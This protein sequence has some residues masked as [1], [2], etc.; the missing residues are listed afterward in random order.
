[1]HRSAEQFNLGTS[2]GVPI[3]L[4][5]FAQLTLVLVITM[6]MDFR[7]SVPLAQFCSS[8]RNGKQ[9]HQIPLM[10]ALASCWWKRVR[11]AG[12]NTVTSLALPIYSPVCDPA[13]ITGGVQFVLALVVVRNSA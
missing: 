12:I 5:L 6:V 7:T 3:T 4:L 10:I 8:L 2:H 13:T 1:M 9:S 11:E